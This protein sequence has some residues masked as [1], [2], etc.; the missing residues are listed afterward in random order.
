MCWKGTTT[1]SS[2]GTINPQATAATHRGYVCEAA[3]TKR[4]P[5]RAPQPVGSR[6]R[7]TPPRREEGRP[8]IEGTDGHVELVNAGE[9]R[10]S[11]GCCGGPAAQ[12]DAR[13]RP[14]GARPS[15]PRGGAGARARAE[16]SGHHHLPRGA[17]QAE[18]GS[19]G[20]RRRSGEAVERFRKLDQLRDAADGAADGRKK[21][22][23]WVGEEPPEFPEMDEPDFRPDGWELVVGTLQ[24]GPRQPLATAAQQRREREEP[25]RR[26]DEAMLRQVENAG[27]IFIGG[28][29]DRLRPEVERRLEFVRQRREAEREAIR[30]LN[31]R[32]EEPTHPAI[33]AELDRHPLA[34]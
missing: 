30:R 12:A 1:R 9:R 28:F 34:S 14:G 2:K 33:Q 29:P 24:R 5:I 11:T 18:R 17:A 10:G 13:G 4:V 6:S 16:R 31:A 22:S 21:V 15:L 26:T 27:G 23:T 19:Q 32:G 3:R 8:R 20:G 25:H 7:S